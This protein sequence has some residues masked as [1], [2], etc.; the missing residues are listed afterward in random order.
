[1]LQE[2]LQKK[3]TLMQLLLELQKIWLEGRRTEKE[4]NTEIG[5]EAVC[6]IAPLA[7]WGPNLGPR[8]SYPTLFKLG[9]AS[10]SIRTKMEAPVA[11][12]KG[13]FRALD[14]PFSGGILYAVRIL[15][16]FFFFSVSVFQRLYFVPPIAISLCPAL[17]IRRMHLSAQ[18]GHLPCSALLFQ[19]LDIGPP[20]LSL[21]DQ[22]FL[23]VSQHICHL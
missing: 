4:R 18:N 12:E 20:V 8:A 11:H 22:T 16:F 9:R 2:R 15:L 13:Y 14:S 6:P 7:P 21:L 17:S 3:K 1:M 23:L 10:L 19:L 5:R